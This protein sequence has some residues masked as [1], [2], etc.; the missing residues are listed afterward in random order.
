MFTARFDERREQN[1]AYRAAPTFFLQF[2]PPTRSQRGV[3][4]QLLPN[5]HG[6]GRSGLQ[7]QADGAEVAQGEQ[8]RPQVGVALRH[9]DDGDGERNLGSSPPL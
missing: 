1:S 3:A 8:I 5:G 7:A 9:D 4:A 2:R 6:K